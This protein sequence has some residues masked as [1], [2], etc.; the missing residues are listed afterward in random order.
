M[1][2]VVE[3]FGS[4]IQGEGPA[5]GRNA[6][7]LRLGGCNL[8]CTWCD[9]PYSWDGTRFDLRKE[10]TNT[11]VDDIIEAVPPAGVLVVTGGEPLLHQGNP[12][13]SELLGRLGSKFP[14]MHLETNGTLKPTQATVDAF[15][16]IA[17]SPKL[18]NAGTHRGR[19]ATPWGGW[20]HIPG[21]FLKVVVRTADDVAEAVAMGWP[22]DRTWVMPE[23]QTPE[24]LAVRWPT[25]AAAAAAWG[26]NATH[27]LHVLAWQTQRGH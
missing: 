17:V 13:W 4:T 3:T 25:I 21:A 9:T 12:Q 6:S 7:F 20:P 8:A 27:R 24:E 19:P 23:G 16:L 11:S 18:G 1:I 22:K 10:I 5:A 26:I 14:E 15:T 2:P